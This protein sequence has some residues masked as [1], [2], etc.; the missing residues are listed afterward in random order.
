MPRNVLTFHCLGDRVENVSCRS[1][2]YATRSVSFITHS[3][4]M[5]TL[6]NLI[7]AAAIF[8]GALILAPQPSLALQPEASQNDYVECGYYRNINGEWELCW[9]RTFCEIKT[10]CDPDCHEECI[11]DNGGPVD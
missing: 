10:V 2:N 8:G 11:A 9:G 5:K 1:G 3:L 6:I 7:S 4:A